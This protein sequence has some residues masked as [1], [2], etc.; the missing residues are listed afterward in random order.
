MLCLA[1]WF[2]KQKKQ[3]EYLFKT[4]ITTQSTLKFL[5]SEYEADP[6]HVYMYFK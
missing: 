5:L 2:I 1:Q 4:Q 3:L 6:M